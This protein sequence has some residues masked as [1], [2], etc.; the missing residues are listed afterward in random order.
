M[1][2]RGREEFR[3]ALGLDDDTWLRARAW[4]LFIA[5]M[6]FPYYWTTMPVRCADRVVMARAVLGG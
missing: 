3:G 5:V 6:T 4:A 2:S 1:D